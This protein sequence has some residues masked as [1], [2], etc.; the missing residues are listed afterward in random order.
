MESREILSRVEKR[1]QGKALREKCPRTSI[2]DWKRR[3]KSLDPIK[4]IQG[5]DVDRIPGLIPLR[6]ERMS[7]S[8]FKFIRGA[9]IIQARGLANSAVSGTTVQA[10]GDC[11]LMNFGAFATPE[12][13]LVFDINDFDETF[14][15]PWEWDPQCL[16]VDFERNR[17]RKAGSSSW[18]RQKEETKGKGVSV[19]G[20][21][22]RSIAIVG[23]RATERI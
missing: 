11:H 21:P 5:T 4:L 8:P 18:Y 14:S 6:H 3:S 1:K 15:G 9:A 10:C 13:A 7:E 2:A 16:P 20:T 12:R 19:R 22:D 17:I 23:R